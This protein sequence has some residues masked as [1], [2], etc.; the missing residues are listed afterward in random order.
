MIEAVGVEAEAEVEAE[1]MALEELA[2]V[3]KL[4]KKR[5][6]LVDVALLY[7][8]FTPIPTKHETLTCNWYNTYMI[9]I[10][11]EF[12]YYSLSSFFV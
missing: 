6:G 3:V 5:T 1:E 12:N 2:L 4:E 9:M 10:S 7:R 8:V 11:I